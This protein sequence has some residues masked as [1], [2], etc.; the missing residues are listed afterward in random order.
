[1]VETAWVLE[2]A[3][4]RNDREIAAAVAAML[5]T[6]ALFIDCE[7]EVFAAMTIVKD[8]LGSLADALIG[9]LGAKAG[10]SRTLTFDQK[11]ARLAGFALP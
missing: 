5:Q 9:A 2:R 10:C 11:A 1:M 3:Y 4:G 6:D 8:G 7:Q